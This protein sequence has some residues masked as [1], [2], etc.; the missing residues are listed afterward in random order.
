MPRVHSKCVF[1]FEKKIRKRQWL[2]T[3]KPLRESMSKFLVLHSADQTS[4]NQ[5]QCSS[6]SQT[7]V[8][9]NVDKSDVRSQS[10]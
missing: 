8:Q 2:A 6:K 3:Q 1:G 7:D 4:I 5:N 10:V 9:E